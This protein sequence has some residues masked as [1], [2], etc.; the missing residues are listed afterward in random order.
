MLNLF[1]TTQSRECQ[2]LD[3]PVHKRDCP[4]RQEERVGRSVSEMSRFDELNHFVGKHVPA[5]TR[6]AG[7]ALD[8]GHDMSSSYTSVFFVLLHSRPSLHIEHRFYAIKAE[9]VPF[10]V[11]GESCTKER[12]KNQVAMAK[13]RQGEDSAGVFFVVVHTVD[14]PQIMATMPINVSTKVLHQMQHAAKYK[15]DP[16]RRIWRNWLLRMLNNGILV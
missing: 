9:V 3:W 15:P 8:L 1:R 13:E 12:H 2:R 6:A 5:I 10:E 4:S 7:L 11:F 14:Q 16:V